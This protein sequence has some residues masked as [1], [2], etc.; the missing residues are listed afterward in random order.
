MEV[1]AA[2]RF[3]NL[4][5]VAL[6]DLDPTGEGTGDQRPM[7]PSD[8]VESLKLM[9]PKLQTELMEIPPSADSPLQALRHTMCQEYVSQDI[10]DVAVVL[11]ADHGTEDHRLVFLTLSSRNFSSGGR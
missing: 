5:T 10:D 7:M 11:C 8:A 2:N 6:L 4:H 3:R 9:W 1:L